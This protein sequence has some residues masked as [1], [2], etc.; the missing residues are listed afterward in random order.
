MAQRPVI[1]EFRSINTAMMRYPEKNRLDAVEAEA[2]RRHQVA[3]NETIAHMKAQF[4]RLHTEFIE[5]ARKVIASN[6]TLEDS[7]VRT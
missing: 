2:A 1:P 4:H 7:E 6:S 3:I 5:T